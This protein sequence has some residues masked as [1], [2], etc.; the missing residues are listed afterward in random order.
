MASM[1]VLDLLSGS[2]ELR[3]KLHANTARFRAG[4]TVAGFKLRPGVHPIIP[5]MLGDAKIAVEFAR[6][7][8][9][10]GIYVIGFSFPVV[11]QGAARIRT[12]ISAAHSEADIDRAIT[13]FAKVARE[14]GVTSG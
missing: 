13:A 3:D 9:D 11:P 10:E 8:L 14:L 1:A 5:I 4:M 6:R 12:Q 2:S 7:L